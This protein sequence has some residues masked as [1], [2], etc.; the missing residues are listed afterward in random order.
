LRFF[1]LTLR[2][3][4]PARA[5]DTVATFSLPFLSQPN[6]NCIP[7]KSSVAEI[8]VRVQN[9]GRK[10]LLREIETGEAYRWP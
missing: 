8:M 7:Y 3:E 9:K 10:G 2:G 4:F 1:S 5:F 6:L